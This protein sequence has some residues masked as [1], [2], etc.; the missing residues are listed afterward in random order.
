MLCGEAKKKK[1]KEEVWDLSGGSLARTP[2]CQSRGPE[3][4]PWSENYWVGQKV[5]VDFSV[6]EKN[7]HELFGQPNRYHVL[8]LSVY[9]ATKTLH[10]QI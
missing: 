3:F 6:S 1:K 7:L 10:S 5:C 2:C 9:A 8:Q 4:D